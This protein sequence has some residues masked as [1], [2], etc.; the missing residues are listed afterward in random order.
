MVFEIFQ[1]KIRFKETLILVT[2]KTLKFIVLSIEWIV[3]FHPD[4]DLGLTNNEHVPK[5]T[6]FRSTTNIVSQSTNGFFSNKI[7]LFLDNF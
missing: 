5:S 2:F 6:F 4:F 3:F 7:L 1:K